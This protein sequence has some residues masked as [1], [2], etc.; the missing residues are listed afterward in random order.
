MLSHSSN[1]YS[2]SSYCLS[3][4]AIGHFSSTIVRNFNPFRWSALYTSFGPFR[5]S[6]LYT[7]FRP[8]RRSTLHTRFGP[9]CWSTLYTSFGP[10]CWSTLYT[11][12][13]PFCSII[14]AFPCTVMFLLLNNPSHTSVAVAGSMSND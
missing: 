4:S 3:R 11:S 6:T 14:V 13:G 8:F 2:Q 12:C 10:F 1:F 9:F 5:R 7:S